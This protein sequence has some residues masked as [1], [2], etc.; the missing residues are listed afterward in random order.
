[1]K[2][3]FPFTEQCLASQTGT[4]LCWPVPSACL[5]RLVSAGISPRAPSCVTPPPALQTTH[6]VALRPHLSSL[7]WN[8]VTRGLAVSLQERNVRT[9]QKELGLQALS[10]KAG[11]M[12][13]SP[14]RVGHSGMKVA[15][16]RMV[17]LLLEVVMG[18][19]S[20]LLVRGGG[21]MGGPILNPL[22]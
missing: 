21:G 19:Q 8:E 17:L 2:E 1:M 9:D 10:S 5:V 3:D 7:T 22:A 16:D 14:P 12:L 4:N 20:L 15:G 11:H 18:P 6:F 13:W